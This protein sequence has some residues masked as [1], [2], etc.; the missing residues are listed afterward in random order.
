MAYKNEEDLPTRK[1]LKK[2]NIE[3]FGCA[4]A[5]KRQ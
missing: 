5:T 1:D 4:G 2:R 3:T